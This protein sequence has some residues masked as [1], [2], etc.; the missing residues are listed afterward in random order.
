M[1]TAVWRRVVRDTGCPVSLRILRR[2]CATLT[3]ELRAADVTVWHPDPPPGHEGHVGYG[4]MG[5]W[6][7]PWTQQRR[8]I[9]A[10]SMVWG[11]SPISSSG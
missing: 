4:L 10:F 3:Q 7:D 8:R 9:W 2:Y 5:L 1:V 6:T 11:A